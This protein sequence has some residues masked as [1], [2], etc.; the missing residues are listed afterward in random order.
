MEPVDR[1][2]DRGR[3]AGTGAVHA[4]RRFQTR[5][6]RLRRQAATGLRGQL[7]AMT[8]DLS[9]PFFEAQHRQLAA[10]LES[11]A[12]RHVTPFEHDESDVDG[13]CRQFV[14][15]LGDGGWLRYAVPKAFGGIHESPDVRRLCLIRETLAP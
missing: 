6:P 8:R 3:S 10:K 9:W 7:T 5:L 11:W 14:A 15:A 1:P 13:L 12:D 4:D 2:G